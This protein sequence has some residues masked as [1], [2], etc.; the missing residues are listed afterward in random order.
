M[1]AGLALLP[2]VGG[3]LESGERHLHTLLCAPRVSAHVV[4]PVTS[5]AVQYLVGFVAIGTLGVLFDV[6]HAGAVAELRTLKDHLSEQLA[7]LDSDPVYIPYV[8]QAEGQFV[9]ETHESLMAQA[10]CKSE[11]PLSDVEGGLSVAE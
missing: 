4:K 2:N 5:N 3:N 10:R 11:F 9:M 1:P 7:R 8:I 6:D